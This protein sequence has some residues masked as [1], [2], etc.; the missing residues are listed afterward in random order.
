MLKCIKPISLKG[1]GSCGFA[2]YVKLRSVHPAKELLG[3]PRAEFCN[4]PRFYD[5]REVHVFLK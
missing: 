3:F 1:V 4:K 5:I 2:Q